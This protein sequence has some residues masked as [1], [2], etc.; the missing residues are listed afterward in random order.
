MIT[1][2]KFMKFDDCTLKIAAE[3]IQIFLKKRNKKIKYDKLRENFFEK[4]EDNTDYFFMPALNFL[5]LLGKVDYNI[6]RDE[7]RLLI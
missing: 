4:Y 6:K 3:I 2:N 7:L 5:Y 1:P